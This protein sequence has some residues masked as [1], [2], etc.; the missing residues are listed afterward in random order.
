MSKG[1]TTLIATLALLVAFVALNIVGSG[2]LRGARLDLTQNKL[3]TLSD[4]AKSIAA[5][6]DEPLRLTL[7]YSEKAANDFPEIRTFAQRVRETLAELA[8]RSGGKIKIEEVDPLPFSQQQDEADQAGIFGAPTG[9]GNDRLYFG[10]VGKNSTDQRQIIPMLNPRSEE[11]LEYDLTRLIYLLSNPKKAVVGLMT[12]LPMEGSAPNPMIRRGQQPWQIVAQLKELFDVKTIP[13]DSASIPADI[14]VLLVAHPKQISERALYAIDQFVMRGGRLV[15]CVDPWCEGDVPAGMDMM[16]AMQLPKASDMNRLFSAWGFEVPTDQIVGDRTNALRV[17]VGSQARPEQVSFVA[18]LGI[19]SKGLNRSDAVTG[20]LQSMN[21][22]SAGVVRKKDGAEISVEPLIES[23]EDS[24]LI[25]AKEIQMLPDPKKLLASFVSGGQKKVLAA[26]VTGKIKSAFPNGDPTKPAPTPDQ[27]APPS[28]PAHLAQSKDS[29][30]AIVVADC[31]FLADRF[32]VQEDRLGGVVLGARKVADNADFLI[33]AL[34]NLAGSSDLISIRAR[35]RSARPF[36]LVESIRRDA[37]Q[38][39][40][41]KEQ[42]LTDRVAATQTKMD[43]LRKQKP[44]AGG[45]LLTPEQK[46]ELANLQKVYLDSRTE[47]RDVQFNLRRDVDRLGTRIKAINIA[48]MPL[49][50]SI[51]AVGLSLWRANRRRSWKR[52]TSDRT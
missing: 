19:T 48:A 22:A 27:P 39:F 17:T 52:Q 9:R 50:I 20:P 25:D 31:D 14:N 18:W 38:K 44:E 51:A 5:K 4:G 21:L 35:G 41:A 29:I 2:A 47:L 13:M 24:M 42:E 34:D 26:R 30:Q 12:S 32:W 49:A 33:Q 15:A 16:Q 37:E 45:A 43:E 36:E 7:Y 6:L 23:S 10:L 8:Q 28:D 40:R 46:Q 3:Y 11:F 1:L